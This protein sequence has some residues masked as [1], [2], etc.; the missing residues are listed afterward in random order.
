MGFGGRTDEEEVRL[1]QIVLFALLALPVLA[2]DP[3]TRLSS[4]CNKAV[5]TRADKIPPFETVCSI[6]EKWTALF[7]FEDATGKA[8]EK[9]KKKACACGAEYVLVLKNSSNAPTGEMEMRSYTWGGV[10]RSRIR[11]S[12]RHGFE[13]VEAVGIRFKELPPLRPNPLKP[14]FRDLKWGEAPPAGLVA[15]WRSDGDKLDFFV[16]PADDMAVGPVFA[17]RIGYAFEDGGLTRVEAHFP[18]SSTARLRFFLI[19]TYGLPDRKAEEGVEAWV[20][21]ED[22]RE[23]TAFVLI[24]ATTPQETTLLM[25]SDRKAETARVNREYAVKKDGGL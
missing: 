23:S 20:R 3:P 12:S 11:P 15:G 18:E 9:V 24:P 14:G 13:E 7:V 25:I 16:R 2:A 17:S 22:P 10:T 19:Q 6:Q 4:T 5:F 21:Y 1:K 8:L